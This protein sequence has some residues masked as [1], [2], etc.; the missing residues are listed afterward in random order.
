MGA[1]LVKDINPAGSSSPNE[2]ISLN[3]LLFFS[4]EL[5]GESAV[6]SED[7]TN[8]NSSTSNGKVGLVR[9]DGSDRGTTILRSFDSVTNLVT[10]KDQLY[11]IAGVEN[12]YQLWTSDG[13]ARGTKQVKDLYPNAD[14][15]FPQDLFEIDGVLFYSAI[16][17]NREGIE[18]SADGG[19]GKYPYVNGYEV[20]R[21]EGEGV[22]SRF[23]RNLV[24]DKIIT[25]I[26]ISDGDGGSLILDANGQP[27]QLKK[28]TTVETTIGTDGTTTTKTTISQE[29]LIN[30]T[31][32]TTTSSNSETRTTIATDTPSINIQ[33]EIAPATE[34][35]NTAQVT[36]TVFENDSFPRDFVSIN[37]NY[38]FTAQSS[39]F[40]SLETK[41]SDVLIGGLELWFS[42]GT[43]GGTTPININQ[44]SYTIYEPQD[45]EYTPATLLGEN[46]FGFFEQSSSSFPRELTPF[47]N[48]LYFVANNGING[49]ELWSITDQ[50]TD[51][52][53]ISDLSKGSTSSSPADLTVVG[54]NL[55]FTANDGSGRKIYYYNESLSE[56]Q[57]IKD[58][59]DNPES[60][61]AIGKKLYY[62]AESELGRELWSIKKSKAKLV[63][64][65]NPGSESSSPNNMVPIKRITNN[66][67]TGTTSQRKRNNYLFFTA[68]D[69]SHG[70][71]LMSLKLKGNSNK[72]KIESDVVN[73][74]PSSFPRDLTNHNQQLFFTA[75]TSAKGRELW[76]V[77]PSIQGPT[78]TS[79][80]SETQISVKENQTFVYQ[81]QTRPKEK[82]IWTING[83]ED[84]SKFKINKENG[85]L[86]FN[87]APNFEKPKDLNK[88]NI[89][90]VFVRSTTKDSGYSSD[91]FTSIEVINVVEN[92]VPYDNN[93]TN[94]I[95]FYT[96]ACGPYTASGPLSPC[97]ESGSLG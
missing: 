19:I 3:G 2:L 71:E 61:T 56:P 16:D 79:G 63:K 74:P 81:F 29:N 34:V 21:R 84:A 60:L 10:T 14:P 45:G 96:E 27:I 9:S 46:D 18:G 15:N 54:N 90:E 97:N 1:R 73:G 25:D 30:G 94:E 6:E 36:T 89:Y 86:I 72:I 62:S 7:N 83:G 20:W 92:S 76:T 58:S 66:K 53:P 38:F 41:T 48:K 50:G 75:K 31:I 43:E 91:Q 12:Q 26:E 77:G 49:F 8:E 5:E 85:R 22:G 39:N 69:G 78:G 95:L 70:V 88:D 42:D 57:I 40:Y 33:E 32:V 52:T 23:F 24:P 55:Y 67:I 64:D 47:N 35:V 93:S 13:T 37:G 51:L 59:G 80:E 87:S 4:A 82:T 65:I 44:N 11:F 68:D 28:T 17:R